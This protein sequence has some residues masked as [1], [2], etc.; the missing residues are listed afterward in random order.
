MPLGLAYAQTR[1][2]APLRTACVA[3]CTLD[4]EFLPARLRPYWL[5]RTPGRYTTY[6]LCASFLCRVGLRPHSHTTPRVPTQRHPASKASVQLSTH[7]VPQ[8]TLRRDTSRTLAH[9]VS[10]HPP[11][12]TPTQIQFNTKSH[13]RHLTNARTHSQLTPTQRQPKFSSTQSPARDTTRTLIPHLESRPPYLDLMDRA[14]L[15]HKDHGAM[16]AR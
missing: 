7:K 3:T 8:E 15:D 6:F 1:N 11:H 9:T 10:S 2:E 16:H 12:P 4:A 13:K 5:L 14:P